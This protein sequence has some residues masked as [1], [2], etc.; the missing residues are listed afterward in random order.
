MMIKKSDAEEQKDSTKKRADTIRRDEDSLWK[1][2]VE[3]FFYPM[4]ERAI[5]T[6]YADADTDTSPRFFG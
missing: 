2:I 6:L 3:R 1:D 5:P 4:L